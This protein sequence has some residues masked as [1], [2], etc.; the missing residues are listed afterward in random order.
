MTSALLTTDPQAT[1]LATLA[2]RVE[3]LN[4]RAVA[5]RDLL[6]SCPNARPHAITVG[7][8]IVATVEDAARRAQTALEAAVAAEVD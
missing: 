8:R 7:R 2:H 1:R 4:R 6:D 5:A 3:V